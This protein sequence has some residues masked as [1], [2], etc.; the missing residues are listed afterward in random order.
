MLHVPLPGVAGSSEITDSP[1]T[2]PKPIIWPECGLGS[3]QQRDEQSERQGDLEGGGRAIPAQ[4]WWLR[5]PLLR[6]TDT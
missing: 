4:P 6:V 3:V 2:L 5:E 1:V